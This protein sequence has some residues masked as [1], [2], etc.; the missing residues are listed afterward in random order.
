MKNHLRHHLPNV[1]K[2]FYKKS[3]KPFRRSLVITHTVKLGIY[4]RDPPQAPL[5]FFMATQRLPGQLV[6]NIILTYL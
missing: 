4:G 6:Y 1:D 2:I 5:R 3:I